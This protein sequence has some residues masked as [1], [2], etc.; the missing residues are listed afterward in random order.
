MAFA[1]EAECSSSKCSLIPALI[2]LILATFLVNAGID[3]LARV[4]SM[5]KSLND[6]AQVCLAEFNKKKCD[7]LALT[8][9]CKKLLNCVQMQEHPAIYQYASAFTEEI[10]TDFPFPT[11]LSGLLLLLHL[12][13]VVQGRRFLTPP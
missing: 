13:Q 2:L 9:E 5:D 4:A 6:Q 8:L 10:L 11:V 12:I 1:E 3:S 7:S